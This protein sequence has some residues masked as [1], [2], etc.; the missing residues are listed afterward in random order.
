[1]TS[2]NIADAIK[3]AV[4]GIL[5]FERHGFVPE[6]HQYESSEPLTRGWRDTNYERAHDGTLPEL[7]LTH[8]FST[9]Y[10]N[11]IVVNSL[12]QDPSGLYQFATGSPVPAERVPALLDGYME[13]IRAGR[14]FVPPQ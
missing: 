14:K 5:V 4:E 11:N 3:K 6:K 1:M 8:S 12:S 9:R 10:G 7:R 13:S 2:P